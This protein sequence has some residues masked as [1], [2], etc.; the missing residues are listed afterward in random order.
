MKSKRVDR[1]N[2]LLKEVISEV[3]SRNVKNPYI[4]ELFTVTQVNVTRDLHHAKVFI[5][6]I[7]SDE[8]KAQT[9]KALNQASGFIA[10]TASSK[11]I[12]RFFPDLTFYLDSG[13]EK[14]LRIDELLGKINQKED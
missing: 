8:E 7:G 6:V 9:I 5:S 13:V 1:L 3:I 14:Q 11:V 10:T 2:S 4:S 12:I